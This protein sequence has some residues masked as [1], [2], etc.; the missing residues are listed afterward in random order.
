[1]KPYGK[2]LEWSLKRWALVVCDS[3]HAK[4]TEKL[5]KTLKIAP[6]HENWS[7]FDHKPLKKCFSSKTVNP[8]PVCKSDLMVW[9]QIS[10]HDFFFFPNQPQH[11]FTRVT[12]FSF[13]SFLS[14]LPFVTF[15]SFITEW[16]LSRSHHIRGVI[17]H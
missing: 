6:P 12:F 16:H 2:C 5:Q 9:S 8:I 1:M 14:F 7:N 13:L 4:R 11:G 10:L 15:H 17:K 3:N